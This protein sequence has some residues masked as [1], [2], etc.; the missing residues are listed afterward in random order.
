MTDCLLPTVLQIRTWLERGE[1]VQLSP[2]RGGEL[3]C[4]P[5][6]PWCTITLPYGDLD[7]L[8]VRR[9]IGEIAGLTGSGLT[10]DKLA[11]EMACGGL[12]SPSGIAM[13]SNRIQ[14]RV[15]YDQ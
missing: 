5:D 10:G 12:V 4:G 6:G 11:A 15:R 7:R 3:W 13:T 8:F 2:A 1:W 14:L 9:L